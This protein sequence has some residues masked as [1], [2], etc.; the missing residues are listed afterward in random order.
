VD[1]SKADSIILVKKKCIP[2]FNGKG[3]FDCTRCVTAVWHTKNIAPFIKDKGS[4]IL[5][6]HISKQLGLFL[7]A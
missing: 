3:T 4:L 1:L 6:V 5:P 7:S 2:L